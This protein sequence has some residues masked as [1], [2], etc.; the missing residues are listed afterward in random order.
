MTE[1]IA[2]RDVGQ[3]TRMVSWWA[4]RKP[5]VGVGP[6]WVVQV[7]CMSEK[8]LGPAWTR[9]GAVQLTT[10]S[11]RSFRRLALCLVQRIEKDRPYFWKAQE[12]SKQTWAAVWLF[13]LPRLLFSEFIPLCVEWTYL[14][15]APEQVLLLGIF[16]GF[17]NDSC[18]ALTQYLELH[19]TCMMVRGTQSDT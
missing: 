5:A 8:M 11:K 13:H 1:D 4:W 2:F 6:K 18:T 10:H 17:R 3:G 7:P 12:T 14:I 19:A 15:P 16:L 9:E